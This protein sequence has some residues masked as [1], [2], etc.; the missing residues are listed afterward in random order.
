MKEYLSTKDVA[1]LLGVKVGTLAKAVYDGRV[2]KPQNRFSG[3]YVW[4]Q[5][6]IKEAAKVFNV[7]YESKDTHEI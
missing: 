5:N 3:N 7:H 6:N 2:K 4:T 1:H